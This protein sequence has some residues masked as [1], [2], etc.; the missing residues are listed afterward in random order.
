MHRLVVSGAC[1]RGP[2]LPVALFLD[3]TNPLREPL[4][5]PIG[6][7]T[8]GRLF[9]AVCGVPVVFVVFG[10]CGVC[11]GLLLVEQVG[12]VRA[13]WGGRPVMNGP[14]GNLRRL[15]SM[16]SRMHEIRNVIEQVLLGGPGALRNLELFAG[17]G[18][19]FLQALT[20]QLQ[21]P[22]A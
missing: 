13:D 22:A 11:R 18:K 21:F 9:L 15:Y 6:E 7:T 20:A 8:Q 14:I 17:T 16:L 5:C 10:A 2:N 19:R 12:R 3:F 1:F 4:I